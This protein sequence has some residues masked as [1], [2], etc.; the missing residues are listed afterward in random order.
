[1]V[2]P[3]ENS[4]PILENLF[5]DDEGVA[6]GN[7]LRKPIKGGGAVGERN[8]KPLVFPIKKKNPSAL[9]RGFLFINLRRMM[10]EWM[11]SLFLKE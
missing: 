4:N 7:A 1:M 5:F 3:W 10:P 8:G 9:C 6:T 11:K 2:N